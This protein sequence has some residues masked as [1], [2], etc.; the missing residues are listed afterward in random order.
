M[1][2]VKDVVASAVRQALHPPGG[3]VSWKHE[4]T[5]VSPLESII[6]VYPEEGQPPRYFTVQVKE[7]Q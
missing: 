4:V 5:Y 1:D 2:K 3:L 6:R 7:N